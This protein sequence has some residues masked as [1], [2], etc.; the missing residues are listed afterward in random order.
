MVGG[1]TADPGR[2]LHAD[3]TMAQPMNLQNF[4][5]TVSQVMLC[6]RWE[7]LDQKSISNE[8]LTLAQIWNRN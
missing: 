6:H 1:D 3:K 8:E 2:N 7:A 5:S 4:P